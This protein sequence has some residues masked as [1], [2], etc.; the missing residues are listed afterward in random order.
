MAGGEITSSNQVDDLAEEAVHLDDRGADG[1]GQSGHIPDHE[2]VHVDSTLDNRSGKAAAP[3]NDLALL[4]SLD[5]VDRLQRENLELAGRV[6]FLQAKLQT[7]EDQL[8]ALTAEATVAE[9]EWATLPMQVNRATTPPAR[10]VPVTSG[11]EEPAP[12]PRLWQRLWSV[13]RGEPV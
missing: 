5:L 11:R 8:L 13:L 1:V 3:A 9:A 10:D 2:P 4:R 12:T 7:T 6:G